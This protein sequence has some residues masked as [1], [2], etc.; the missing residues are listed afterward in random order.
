MQCSCTC[1]QSLGDRMLFSARQT[2]E[3]GEAKL[4]GLNHNLLQ[5]KSDHRCS[6]LQRIKYVSAMPVPSQICLRKNM[7]L[8]LACASYASR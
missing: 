2:N 8:A 3:D 7:K 1:G 4:P 6:T 5:L